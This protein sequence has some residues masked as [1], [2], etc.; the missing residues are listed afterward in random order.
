MGSAFGQ[1]NKRADL[2]ALV[3]KKVGR[4]TDLQVNQFFG[5]FSGD[6]RD[7]ALVVAYYASRGGGNSF[8]IAVMLFEAVGSGFRYLR[9][10]P[11]V[12]GESPRGATFQRGQIKVTLT[13]LGPND[14][15]CCPS[16]PKEYTIRTP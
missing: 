14:A 6:G 16:V 4:V 8:E 5:D 12:Y 10:V 7:D 1:N 9:D 11:N 15:R 2:I 13:T 3:K